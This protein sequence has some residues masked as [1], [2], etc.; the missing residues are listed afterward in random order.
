MNIIMNAV[1]ITAAFNLPVS[2]YAET[3]AKTISK[4]KDM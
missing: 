1:V 2:A 4:M 3:K